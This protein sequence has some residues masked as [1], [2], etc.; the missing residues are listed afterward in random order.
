MSR[1]ECHR[2]DIECAHCNKKYCNI[3]DLRKHLRIVSTS[4]S[5]I[6]VDEKSNPLS[7]YESKNYI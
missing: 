2:K 4:T 6:H 1:H 3:Q 7:E 5:N